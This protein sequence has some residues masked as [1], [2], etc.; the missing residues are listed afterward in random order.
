[1]QDSILETIKGLLGIISPY[2]AYDKQIIAM[3]NTAIME[4]QQAGVGPSAPFQI[5]SNQEIWSDFL[6]NPVNLSAAINYIHIKVAIMFDQTLSGPTIAA[7]E[8]QLQEFIWRLN[9]AV[10]PETTFA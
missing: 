5:T 6:T 7:M 3:I 10:D 8:R 9:V 2:G 1:M 4:L